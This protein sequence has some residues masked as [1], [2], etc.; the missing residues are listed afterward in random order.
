MDAL[1][2]FGRAELPVAVFKVEAE[3]FAGDFELGAVEVD[4]GDLVAIGGIDVEAPAIR[5]S[6]N[7][8]EGHLLP[9]HRR[10]GNGLHP[11]RGWLTSAVLA[12]CSHRVTRYAAATSH[13]SSPS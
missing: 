1:S 2:C 11:M 6:A 9:P 8:I 12:G 5:M 3:F 7:E 4:V 10:P 13:G